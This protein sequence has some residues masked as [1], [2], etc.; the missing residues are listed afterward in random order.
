MKKKI[1]P[2]VVFFTILAGWAF[3][4]DFSADVVFTGRG[5]SFKGKIFSSEEKMRM[6]TPQAVSITRM[7]KK[8]VWI[9][10]PDE[11]MYMEQPVMPG[12]VVVSEKEKIEGEVER[13]LV[14]SETVDG[15]AAKKYR[16]V[17]KAGDKKDSIYQW[18]A[19][20]SGFTIKVAAIDGSWAMEYKNLKTGKQPGSL[21]EVPPGYTKFSMPSPPGMGPMGR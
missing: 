21:F 6:E 15:K 2:M 3:A 9:L 20:D 17:Y 10:M 13:A 5:E 11:K 14:S 7:D 19:N 18:V 1:I 16:V 8:V 12:N 4:G